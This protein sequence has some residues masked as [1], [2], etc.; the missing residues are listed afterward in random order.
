MYTLNNIFFKLSINKIKE[1]VLRSTLVINKVCLL[2]NKFLLI[3]RRSV[4]HVNHGLRPKHVHLYVFKRVFQ[5]VLRSIF[6]Q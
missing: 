1:K 3:D 2:L 5:I 4:K 6:E